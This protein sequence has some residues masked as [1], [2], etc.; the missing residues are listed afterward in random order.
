MSWLSRFFGDP[1]P[2]LEEILDEPATELDPDPPGERPTTAPEAPAEV[3]A[4]AMAVD[5]AA[6]EATESALAPEE[7][8]TAA[9]V[10]RRFEELRPGTPAFP[11]IA[12]EILERVR[13]PRSDAAGLARTIE[14]DAALS[15]G[16]LALANSAVFRG[17]RVITIREAIARLGLREVARTAAALSMRPLYR[18]TQAAAEHLRAVGGGLFAHA[19]TVARAGAGLARLR[20]LGDPGLVFLG[21]MLHD[22]GKPL[23]LR[24]LSALLLAGDVPSHEPAA[25]E[26]ILHDLHVP[27]GAAAH[28]AW[29]LPP[30]LGAIAEW[31]HLPEIAPGPEQ[32]E[33][34]VVRLS[35]AL[36]LLRASPGVSTT[37]PEEVVSSARALGLGPGRVSALRTALAEHRAWVTMLFSPHP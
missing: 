31:H 12:L 10:L 25:V 1:R 29:G 26:R 30:P 14:V 4:R 28:R 8:A 22:V 33:L 21:G 37:A 13:D 34:H 3:W 36:E 5:P 35:S 32:V 20:G 6:L 15:S 9:A 18:G 16:V 27:I 7:A 24:S 19:V 2:K 17:V 11:S 23:A